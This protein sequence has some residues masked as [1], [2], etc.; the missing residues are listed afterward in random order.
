MQKKSVKASPVSDRNFRVLNFVWQHYEPDDDTYEPMSVTL[1]AQFDGSR[2]YSAGEVTATLKKVVI[3]KYPEEV[4]TWSDCTEMLAHLDGEVIHSFEDQFDKPCTFWNF[5]KLH[6]RKQKYSELLF[7][8]RKIDT[9]GTNNPS[10]NNQSTNNQN[11][12]NQ[13][14]KKDTQKGKYIIV[15]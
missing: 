10:T 3:R 5:L 8:T 13:S 15:Q 4:D 2:D 1:G 14:T 12:N 9:L 7:L 6:K 11:I